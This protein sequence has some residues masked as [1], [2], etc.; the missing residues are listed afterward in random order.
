M[1]KQ[2]GFT[3]VELLL[4][5]I[6]LS[7]LASIGTHYLFKTI[8]NAK[9]EASLNE[10]RNIANSLDIFKKRGTD[11]IISFPVSGTIADINLSQTT[12]TIIIL[13]ETNKFDYAY[14]YNLSPTIIVSTNIPMTNIL[15][16]GISTNDVAT[17]TN[18]T[19]ITIHYRSKI[20][21]TTNNRL[22][23]VR[24]FF[25]DN[26]NIVDLENRQ[27]NTG[28]FASPTVITYDVNEN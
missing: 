8:D 14:H 27:R 23:W 9:I 17:A 11:T 13:P 3:F 25:Y 18:A 2:Q 22:N 5:V 4:I 10:M 7:I 6:L 26:T 15:P 28:N 19:T 20:I 24:R 21:N 1:S 16:I 12:N